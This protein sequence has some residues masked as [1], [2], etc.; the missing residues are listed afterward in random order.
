[1]A[2]QLG[3]VEDRSMLQSPGYGYKITPGRA[4]KD[5]LEKGQWFVAEHQDSIAAVPSEYGHYLGSQLE[6]LSTMV[7]V[8]REAAQR[9]GPLTKEELIRQTIA[10]KPK[11]TPEQ[12]RLLADDL[13]DRGT[14]KVTSR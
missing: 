13:L 14:L 9:N 5:V 4:A 2:E 10:I 3:A 12:A 11:Y 1:M 6:L 8:D 7:F